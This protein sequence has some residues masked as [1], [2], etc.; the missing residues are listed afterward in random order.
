MQDL[1]TL[2]DFITNVGREEKREKI[3]TF[4]HFKSAAG[5]PVTIDHHYHT[6]NTYI[7]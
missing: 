1:I 5:I 6:K 7:G 3:N 2:P 4:H